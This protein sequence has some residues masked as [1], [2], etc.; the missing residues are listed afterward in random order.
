ME[1]FS[2][3][4][5]KMAGILKNKK[6]ISLLLFVIL[7]IAPFIKAPLLIAQTQ[8]DS[9]SNSYEN[10]GSGNDVVIEK[11][12][13]ADKRNYQRIIPLS[14]PF[15]REIDRLY[16]LAGKSRPSLSRPWSA[17]EAKKV[18]EALPKNLLGS[19]TESSVEI[20]KREIEFG[21]EKTGTKKMSSKISQEI[22]VEAHIKANDDREEWEHGY[23]AR[24]PLIQIPLEWWFFTGFYMDIEFSIR[25]EYAFVHST[26]NYSSISFFRNSRGVDW[27]FPFRA[28]ASFGGEHWNFQVGKDKASWGAG[29]V[30]NQMIS[31]YS[32]YYNMIKFS[33]YWSRFKFTI[34]Y[35]GLEAWLTGEEEDFRSKY[36]GA[37][38]GDYEDFNESFKCFIAKR[39]E[40]K[41]LDNL[42]FAISEAS[43]FG[44]KY[45]N[46]SELNPFMV[47]HN[48]YTPAYSNVM[49]T[50]ELDYT[51]FS[52]FNIYLQFGMD[53]FQFPGVE[54]K[55]SRPGA[56]GL[57]SGFTFI[58]PAYN[59]FLTFNLEAAYTD[60]YLYNRWHP[61]T[62]F[63]NRRK[64]WASDDNGYISKPIGYKYGPDAIVIYQ[65]VQYEK[66]GNYM[67]AIDAKFIM[68]GEKNDLDKPGLY[69][70][71]EYASNLWAPSGTVERNL[72]IGLHGK[73][74]AT[75]TIS[76]ASDI[77]YININNYHNVSGKT[78]NDF[79]FT[80]SVGFK[81]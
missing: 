50:L 56:M 1:M 5:S 59:G 23:E 24:P 31:D 38:G 4:F 47:F 28:F 72:L 43:M 13:I 20:I 29:T 27:N 33:T 81:F 41:I 9:A 74:Q 14:S 69:E 3:P 78:I 42:S 46:I 32:D 79:E 6:Y 76:L 35:I 62:K 15:Y 18:F 80:A 16:L 77:Y 45:I 39:M 19:V 37:L 12:T 11:N 61:N 70:L 8:S 66:P 44:N 26:D 53:E 10:K 51:P 65:A 22:N 64:I 67:A 57:I 73:L 49:M 17:D 54:D 36:D 63:T 60:P 40:F 68:I 48:L 25:E 55:D 71:G 52:G 2:Y 21:N 58:K 34:V 7:T 30:S 75:K